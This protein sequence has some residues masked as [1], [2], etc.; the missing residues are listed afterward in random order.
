MHTVTK[1]SVSLCVFFV[2]RFIGVAAIHGNQQNILVGAVRSIH[3]QLAPYLFLRPTAEK[4]KVY[5]AAIWTTLPSL[6]S[7][8]ARLGDFLP[9][10]IEMLSP[11]KWQR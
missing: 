2:R 6:E 9:F 4:L 10:S 1:L 7:L 5:T 11:R 8:L 3:T